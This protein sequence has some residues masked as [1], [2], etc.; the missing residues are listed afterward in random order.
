VSTFNAQAIL[1]ISGAAKQSQLNDV[2]AL[3]TS[4]LEPFNLSIKE[5]QSISLGGRIIIATLIDCDSAHLAAIEQDL[6]SAL[7]SR[8]LDVATEL[9]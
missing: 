8:N 4:T 2:Q 9:V 5:T 1:L 3:M 7:K 6:S